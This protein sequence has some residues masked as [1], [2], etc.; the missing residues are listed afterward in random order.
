MARV[1]GMTEAGT[2]REPAFST[3]DHR[4]MWSS[5]WD[6]EREPQQL[7][8]GIWM[9]HGNANT[10]LV[11]G[12]AGSPGDLV[13]NP[14]Y[15]YQG[16]LIRAKLEHA[17]GRPLEAAAIVFT[18][19]HIDHVGGWAAFAR[20]DTVLYAQE[21]MPTTR[22][23]RALLEPY[24]AARSGRLFGEK[25]SLA[26]PAVRASIR[27]AAEPEPL[28]LVADRA[29]IEVGGRQVELLAVPGGECLDGL[30]V[31][32]P[33]E[34]VVF[35]GYL[36]GPMWGNLPNLSTIRG[37]RLRSATTF[38]ESADRVLALQPDLLVTGEG[39][40]EG[41]ARIQREL[42]RIRDAVQWI[43]DRT[44]EGMNAGKDVHTL[45]GEITLPPELEVGQ[46]RGRVAWLV[47]AVWEEY[48]NWF[49][50][51][52][53]TELYHVPEQAIRGEL[54]ELAGG[55]DVLAARAQAHLD[56]GRP[57]EALHFTD[58][59]LAVDPGH[60]GALAVQCDALVEL[61]D[62]SGGESFDE[63]R[64]LETELAQARE[65]LGAPEDASRLP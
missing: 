23:E 8:D 25:L 50:G 48:S 38:V 31:W 13:V 49:R 56:A 2:R 10:Y 30:A 40:V 62:R 1:G 35:T 36:T 26:D 6:P 46:Q 7:R 28:T 3:R 4:L 44:V 24:F 59:A 34:R 51:R 55:P 17:V 54:A 37:D 43:H 21:R 63:L 42:G 27:D 61:I 52:S 9:W 64:W 47:R 65:R 22:T 39:P 15:P 60:S 5:S 14:G 29:R 18:Q 11:T 16:E 33:D 53:T 19:S 45:M 32:L 57:L 20:P 12:R 41:A 58:I